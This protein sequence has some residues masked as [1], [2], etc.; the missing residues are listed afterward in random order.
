MWI[1]NCEGLIFLLGLVLLLSLSPGSGEGAEGGALQIYTQ[2]AVN[3]WLKAEEAQKKA[4]A[5]ATKV[6]QQEEEEDELDKLLE[7]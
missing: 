3:G 2:C 6:Q 4:D 1:M 7:V 5:A